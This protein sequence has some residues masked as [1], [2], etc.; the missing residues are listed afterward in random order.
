VFLKFRIQ[1]IKFEVEGQVL[2]AFFKYAALFDEKYL[3]AM[4][5]EIDYKH[6]SSVLIIMRR[7]IVESRCAMTTE[8]R[9]PAL[10]ESTS[11]RAYGNVKFVEMFT[12]KTFDLLND[13][14]A[15]TV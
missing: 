1:K 8:V 10:L 9:C 15:F 6:E 5:L 4:N 13:E 12:H 14:F 3:V 7:T 11:S 2:H